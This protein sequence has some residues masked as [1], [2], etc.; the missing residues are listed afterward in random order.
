LLIFS[1]VFVKKAAP[2]REAA[3][4]NSIELC[5]LYFYEHGLVG[6]AFCQRG[7]LIDGFFLS[8]ASANINIFFL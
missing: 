8:Q 1:I 6:I 5:L 3:S 4:L 7:V 2:I